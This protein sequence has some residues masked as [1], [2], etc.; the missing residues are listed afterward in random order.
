M[1]EAFHKGY[2]LLSRSLF[3]SN[4]WQLPPDHLRVAIY[5]LGKA[6]HS[7]KPHTLPDGLTIRRGEL[8][9]SMTFISENCSY[10]ENR[11]VREMSRKKALNI[12]ENLE[13][14]G[15]LKR[16]SHSKGTHISICNYDTYQC[17]DN[18][19][20][21]KGETVR[22]QS[23]NSEGTLR[24]TNKNDNNEKNAKKVSLSAE[25]SADREWSLE[26]SRS[27][28]IKLSE[29]LG[30]NLIS[31]PE[32]VSFLKLLKAG[33]E[34]HQV[35]SAVDFVVEHSGEEFFP[36]V[37]SS[38]TF[39]RKWEKIMDAKRRMTNHSKERLVTEMS[40]DAW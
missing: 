40:E 33:V 37:E 11:M 38:R 34:K 25:E 28:K 9:T 20:P 2:F 10:Y 31:K 29:K 17:T 32:S 7:T 26:L 1:S 39:F 5:L 6:R 35:E 4:L 36:V 22:E 24:D 18:Y 15:F 21:H 14:I 23:G 12:L 13:K 19:N 16:N 8:V 30:R 27:L 3:D